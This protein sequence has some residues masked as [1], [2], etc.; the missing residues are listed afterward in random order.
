M[1]RLLDRRLLLFLL[2]AVMA[3]SC[4]RSN[5]RGGTPCFDNGD[6]NDEAGSGEEVDIE[7]CI[8]GECDDVDCLSSAD[9]I[10]GQYCDV[11]GEAYRCREGCQG[12]GDCFAGQSCSDDGQCETY[13]CRST[14][15][16]CDFNEICNQDSGECEEADTLQCT[17]C[18]QAGNYRDDRG[19]ADVCDDLI[20]G[21]QLCG[22]DGNVC[23]GPQGE[24]TCWM[25]CTEAGGSDEC[26]AGFSCGFL[27]FSP[28]FGCPQDNIIGPYC[29]PNDG[30]DPF[31]P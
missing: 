30:C 17:G 10:V 23:A 8:D 13:G 22:G 1:A 14:I 3:I 15:L 7:A 4:G 27:L 31:S 29:I 18:D 16:D 21:H 2:V 26:P 5:R 28:G 11:D 12:D 24:S 25:G 9:C 20:G 6:C 19:T